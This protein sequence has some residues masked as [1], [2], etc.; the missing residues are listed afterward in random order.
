M[1][2][3]N[4]KLNVSKEAAERQIQII[5]TFSSEKRFKIALDF[6]NMGIYQTRNWIKQQNPKFTD[7]E[8]TKE[9]VRIIY[10]KTGEMPEREWLFFQ[11]K[12][13]DK[14]ISSKKV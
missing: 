2:F 3:W 9:F 6:A 12:I 10:Y 7:L 11:K 14:I 13:D 4:K 8:I 1:D 5:N